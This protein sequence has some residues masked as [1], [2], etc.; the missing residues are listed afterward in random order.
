VEASRVLAARRALQ[1]GD[2]GSEQEEVLLAVVA[3]GP[4]R[5]ET[6]GS[7][8]VEGTRAAAPGLTAQSAADET[9]SATLDEAEWLAKFRAV[10]RRILAEYEGA[11][12]PEDPSCGAG[13]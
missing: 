2:L 5:A 1:A 13:G 6:G 10:D 9:D 11:A 7:D 3:P 12:H 4:S 8:A